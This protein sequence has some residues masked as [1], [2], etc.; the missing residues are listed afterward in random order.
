MRV[1]SHGR[2]I[3]A[4]VAAGAA[5]AAGILV[6]AAPAGATPIPPST[7]TCTFTDITS[8]APSSTSALTVSGGD[9]VSIVCTG[10]AANTGYASAIASP[11]AQI[12][13]AH[14]TNYADVAA[15]G[16]S[17][18]N[19]DG[20][21]NWSYTVTVPP[22]GNN[23]GSDPNS[24]CPPTQAQVNAG[25]TNCVLGIATALQV[26]ANQMVV[27]YAD[28]PTPATPTVNVTGAPKTGRVGDTISVT[29]SGFWGS[30]FG[31]PNAGLGIPAP[32]ASIGANPAASNL[33][34]TAPTYT[35]PTLTPGTLSGTITV[36]AGSGTGLPVNVVEANITSRP[37]N[38][39]SNSVLGTAAGAFN[40]L[41]AAAI[42]AAPNSG[43]LGV[44]T[45]VTGSGFDP[46]GGPVT[47]AF[48]NG[49]PASSVTTSVASDGT[50]SV[51]L[52]VHAADALGSN[53]I[54]ATQTA[55]N[56]DILS[57]NT[58]FT[59][60]A[61]SGGPCATTGA[62]SSC[63]VNQVIDETVTGVPAG[64]IIQDGADNGNA[65]CA[66]GNPDPIHVTLT[67][68][69]LNGKTQHATGC[70]NTVQV[71][72]ERG[73]LVGY[74]A[75]GVL[76]TDFLGGSAG[77]HDWDKV[78]PGNN[79]VWTPSRSLTWPTAPN[80]PSGVLSEVAAGPAGPVSVASPDANLLGGGSPYSSPE[81]TTPNVLA[82]AAAGGG[83]GTFNL[84]AG[85]DLTVPAWVSSG[86]YQ[87]TMDL[88]VT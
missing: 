57:A 47:V 3:G 36:P 43:G 61:V 53:P 84:N 46:Q 48:S 16:A 69:T 64:L 65:V 67:G 86:T 54:T 52:T 82:T 27:N 37:G 9:H 38:G 78:I 31:A 1:L 76:E 4:L 63:L 80:G 40:Y 59:V 5:G 79:L 66:A 25:L 72:D 12:D 15:G 26:G 45:T 28:Q 42:S 85:L 58:G 13:A 55:A 2:R 18:H 39:P 70:L 88:V 23:G 41:S 8:G 19:S 49:T 87:A 30:N 20:S 51:G 7:S 60:S 77:A 32:S 75:T 50:I 17:L 21:G 10:L 74:T 6:V 83:G 35:A 24:Q 29:G 33:T 22:E 44:T 11:L 81:T 71:T 68:T 56:S 34:I 62:P 73:N 14:A